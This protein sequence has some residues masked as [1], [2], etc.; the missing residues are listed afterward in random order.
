MDSHIFERM[1]GPAQFLALL[2]AAIAV[3]LLNE[4]HQRAFDCGTVEAVLAVKEDWTRA[5]LC[6]ASSVV[7]AFV[8]WKIQQVLA[9]FLQAILTCATFFCAG[10]TTGAVLGALT[11]GALAITGLI[12]TDLILELVIGIAA[13]GGVLACVG[14]VLKV[15]EERDRS[16]SYPDC[17]WAVGL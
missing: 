3:L 9:G 5:I 14:G 16:H 13:G 10:A 6:V 11:G 15:S 12:P 17:G 7:V 1:H 2:C 4:I 8:G